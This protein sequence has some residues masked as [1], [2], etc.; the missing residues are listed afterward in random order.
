M[1]R[2]DEKLQTSKNLGKM[3]WNWGISCV[4]LWLYKEKNTASRDWACH[5]RK[6]SFATGEKWN[7]W[8]NAKLGVIKKKKTG[9]Q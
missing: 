9:R 8:P 5:C 6:E 2:L 4:V 7:V 3:R 1:Q